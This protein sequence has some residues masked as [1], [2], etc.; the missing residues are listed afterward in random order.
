MTE[1]PLKKFEKLAKEAES[2]LK[3]GK[4]FACVCTGTGCLGRGADEILSKFEEK[5]GKG[6]VSKIS[7][8]GCRG[9]C[10]QG[11]LVVI[12]PD[13][14]LYCHVSPDDVD[15]IT[16]KSIE[17]GEIIERLTYKDP[18]SGVHIPLLKDIPFFSGQSKLALRHVGTM[19]PESLDCALAAGVYRALATVLERNDPDWVIEEIKA[20]GLRGRGGGG[21]SAGKKWEACKNAAGDEKF[22]VCNGDEG[23]PGAFMDR[24]IMEGDPHSVLEGMAIGAFAIGASRGFIY[25]REEYPLATARLEKAIKD[26]KERGLLGENI[27]GSGFSFNVSISKGAG[28]FVCGESSA[29]MKA[30]M[31]FPGEPRAK[32]IRTVV[33]GYNDKPTVL[34]NVETLVNVPAII[35]RGAKWFRSMG[36]KG[37]PGTKV[38]SLVGKVKNTGLVEV[39]MGMTLRDIVEKIGGG[40]SGKGEIK[41]VQTGGPSGGCLP[42]DKLDIPVDFDTLTKEGSMMGSGGLVVMDDRTCMVDVAR[43]FT[44][45]LA[46]ESCGKCVPCR[47]GVRQMHL[48]LERIC[49]GKG[50]KEDIQKLERLCDTVARASLCGLGK[51]A[52]NPLLSV[53]KYFRDELTAHIEERRCPAGV[54][55]ALVTYRIEESECT[56]CTMCARV[57]PANAI[58]G[59]AGSPHKINQDLCTKCGACYEVCPTCAVKVE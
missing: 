3:R 46:N 7:K 30:L 6:R 14:I 35:E 58:T 47:E 13:G 33:R 26:A 49:A 23:D 18:S 10:A 51:S 36:T 32:Y 8:G 57:C 24:S 45:F 9:F 48:I 20:S 21:F 50:E 4:R 31:G 15:E 44:S 5:L 42:A 37:S 11:P 17:R 1:S 12:E 2:T 22:F 55:R 25:V 39:P 28:A 41:A 16:D 43:Y 27:L 34:N 53:L 52:P 29:L 38:F 19:D 54:C 59:T 56:G 40:V